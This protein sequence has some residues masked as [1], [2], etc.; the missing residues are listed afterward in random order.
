MADEA[1]AARWE[2]LQ[3]ELSCQ[4]DTI[5]HQRQEICRLRARLR[6][7]D[8]YDSEHELLWE[9]E[10]WDEE[11]AARAQAEMLAAHRATPAAGRSAP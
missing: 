8:C 9:E 10:P 11:T 5:F 4:R 2:A 7:N 3:A 6:E 1:A